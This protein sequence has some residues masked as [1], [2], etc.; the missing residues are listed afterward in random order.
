MS[1]EKDTNIDEQAES[2]ALEAEALKEEQPS[3]SEQVADELPVIPGT[4]V[5]A[6]ELDKFKQEY[7][8]VFLTDYMGKRYLWHRLNRKKFGEICDATE[9]IKDDDEL[10]SAREKEFVKACVLYPGAEEVAEDVEDE[11]ISSRISREI[12]FKS[13]FYQPTTVEL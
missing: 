6:A 1:K 13:G 3:E 4:T 9:D 5:T 11:M 2:A 10:L 7:K 8:K 12:L